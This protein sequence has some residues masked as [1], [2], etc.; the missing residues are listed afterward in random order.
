M[1]ADGL[2]IVREGAAGLKEVRRD[3]A[4]LS[5]LPLPCGMPAAPRE[6]RRLWYNFLYK[7]L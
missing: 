4:A 5:L 3:A 6:G 2:S 1:L 7:K